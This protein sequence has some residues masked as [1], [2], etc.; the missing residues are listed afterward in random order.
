[1]VTEGVSY[2]YLTPQCFL[3]RSARVFAD[4][5]A[6]AYGEQQWTYAQFATRVNQLANAL[7]EWGLEKGDRV[8]FLCPN[9]PPL[10]EAHFAIPLAGGILIAINS[11][12]APKDIAYILNDSGARVL[13]VD[14]ELSALIAPIREELTHLEAIINIVDEQA[15]VSAEK[16]SELDYETFLAQGSPEPVASSL[17]SEN[18]PITINYTSGTSGQPKGV[19]YSHRAVYLNAM[20]MALEIGMNNRSVYLWTLPM[21]HCN[22]WCFPWGVVA[23]GGTH[24]CLRKFT[25]KTALSLMMSEKVT[26]FCGSPTLL[27]M[28]ANDRTIDRLQLDNTITTIVGGAP[29]SPSLIEKMES[30][31]I[32]LIHGY[33]LTETYGPHTLCV[34]QA[35]WNDLSLEEQAKI[36]A[37]QGVAT[38]HATHLRV[39]D[40]AMNDVPADGETLGEVVM[41]GNNVMQGYFNDP[42]A[43]ESA[44]RGGWFHSGDLAVM[45]PGGYIELRDRAKDI[46]ISKGM[47]ISTIEI[48]QAMYKHP[49][50]LEVAAIAIPDKARGEVPKVFVKLK[51]ETTATEDELLQ[52]VRQH[53]AQFKWPKAIEFT[54]LP[55]TA[56]GKVQKYL[57]R[58]NEWGDRD[59]QIN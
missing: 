49:A 6:I 42:E 45:H 29:P 48:E 52:F 35:P 18:D 10:I 58:Q 54:D 24:I 23:V 30:L 57:L 5:V 3:D 53:L 15:N 11:R 43:T 41:R 22:G 26:H 21:F 34:W 39:V 12:L 14:T 36:K 20:G 1:M 32:H 7:Q 40:E 16:L 8:A 2:H 27:I 37:R 33:G 56:T 28:L 13:C 38:V 59:K 51:P 46:I 9:I 31:G 25:P 50:V 47:N 19:V 4:K 55:K 44:C 17:D